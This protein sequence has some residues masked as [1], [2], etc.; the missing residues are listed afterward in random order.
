MFIDEHRDEDVVEPICR[1][2]QVA[3]STYYVRRS[4]PPSARSIR[5]AGLRPVIRQIH[6][7]LRR[8]RCPENPRGAAQAGHSGGAVHR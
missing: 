4:R 6:S 5:D 8:L 7:K 1:V 3:P 2:L